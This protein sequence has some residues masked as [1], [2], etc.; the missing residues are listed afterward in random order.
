MG[1]L[2]DGAEGNDIDGGAKVWGERSDRAS[3]QRAATR[4]RILDAEEAQRRAK[5]LE[6]DRRRKEKARL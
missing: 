5:K 2:A 3:A 1:T 6:S 4:Q